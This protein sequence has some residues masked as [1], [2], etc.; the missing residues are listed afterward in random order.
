MRDVPEK[1]NECEIAKEALQEA[2]KYQNYDLKIVFNNN[3]QNPCMGDYGSAKAKELTRAVQSNK[4]YIAYG[5]GCT[6]GVLACSATMLVATGG[7][8]IGAVI[9]NSAKGIGGCAISATTLKFIA[10]FVLNVTLGEEQSRST[11]YILTAALAGGGTVAAYKMYEQAKFL[12]LVKGS[13]S[14]IIGY[15][16]TAVGYADKDI[17]G[18]AAASLFKAITGLESGETAKDMTQTIINAAKNPEEKKKLSERL[19]ALAKLFR[20]TDDELANS[21]DDLAKAVDKVTEN[22]ADTVTERTIGKVTKSFLKIAQNSG[23]LQ[24]L[25]RRIKEIQEAKKLS[26]KQTFICGMFGQ[27]VGATMASVTALAQI[28]YTETLTVNVTPKDVVN[29]GFAYDPDLHKM[30]VAR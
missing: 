6:A 25:I 2:S 3:F 20:G 24:Q 23:R 18:A 7:T 11:Q 5:L 14:Q 26:E 12:A 13:A 27:A 9:V 28:T 29:I 4:P 22:G 30:I 1:G 8:S 19:R 16:E 15:L 10:P 17:D 21:L